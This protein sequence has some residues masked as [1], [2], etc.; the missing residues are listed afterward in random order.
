MITAEQILTT[1]PQLKNRLMERYWRKYELQS[2]LKCSQGELD[3]I[4]DVLMAEC[5]LER[6]TQG[7]R[8]KLGQEVEI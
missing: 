4:I 1:Y 8:W 5:L 6:S 2:L 7:W 3:M